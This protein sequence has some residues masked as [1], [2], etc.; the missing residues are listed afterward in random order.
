MN[1]G[2]EGKMIFS[3]R[4]L[5]RKFLKFL[6]DQADKTKIRV[7]AYCLMNNHYHLVLQNSSGKLSNFMRNLNGSFGT[8][9]RN[10]EGGKG[11]VFQNRFKS[12]LITTD[13]YLSAVIAYTL[14]NPLRA[15]LVEDPYNYEW[16][17]INEYFSNDKKTVTDREFVENL[18][19]SQDGLRRHLSHWVGRELPVKDTDQGEVIGEEKG[20]IR[21]TGIIDRAKEDVQ[22]FPKVQVVIARF[23]M[24]KGV[25]LSDIDLSSHNG[26]RLRAELLV[27]LKD[28][29]GLTYRE[30][31]EMSI[32]ETLSYSS[33]GKIYQRTKRRL[34][35]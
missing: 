14:L 22:R 34:A 33:L 8:T 27:R 17:S 21:R 15:G 19:M 7:F 18:F 28:D 2:H 9:Y 3:S 25:E 23:E 32:F 20:P 13:H 30:I 1:R 24:E 31:S 12:T 5:K 35:T 29:A 4:G 11:Y 26:K 6:V 10:R 16:S